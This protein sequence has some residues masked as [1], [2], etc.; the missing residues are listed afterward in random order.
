MLT[1]RQF[2]LALFVIATVLVDASFLTMVEQESID[3]HLIPV[4]VVFGTVMGQVGLMGIF[5]AF[6]ERSQLIRLGFALGILALCAKMMSEFDRRQS[7]QWYWFFLIHLLTVAIPLL[8]SKRSRQF[9][10]ADLFSL[11]TVACI[12]LAVFRWLDAH[13]IASLGI[14]A[15]NFVFSTV[16]WLTIWAV[17]RWKSPWCAITIISVSAPA[18]GLVAGFPAYFHHQASDVAVATTVQAAWLLAGLM[19]ARMGNPAHEQASQPG[20]PSVSL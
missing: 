10:L 18:I 7:Y 1:V 15:M 6:G 19:I 9:S 14:A 2:L 13:S 8:I 11:T 20:L 3:F 17:W 5:L 16:V 4:A 12:L